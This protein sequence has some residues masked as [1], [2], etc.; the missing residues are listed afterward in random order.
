M[1][2]YLYAHRILRVDH[3]HRRIVGQEVYLFPLFNID[4]DFPAQHSFLFFIVNAIPDGF[5]SSPH[6]RPYNQLI[7][8]KAAVARGDGDRSF[9]L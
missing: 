8:E 7:S 4:I 1:H 6:V 2:R 9:L 5:P 3:H